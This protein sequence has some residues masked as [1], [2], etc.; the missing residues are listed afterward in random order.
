MPRVHDLDD[1]LPPRH[2][3]VCGLLIAPWDLASESA[4]E[5]DAESSVLTAGPL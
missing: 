1:D 2:D 4:H 5:T 3:Q